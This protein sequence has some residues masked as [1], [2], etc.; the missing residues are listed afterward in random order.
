MREEAIMAVCNFPNLTLHQAL[1][2]NLKRLS[3][4]SDIFHKKPNE[5]TLLRL[6]TSLQHRLANSIIKVDST[7]AVYAN[8]KEMEIQKTLE[9]LK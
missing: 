1:Y 7:I 8:G 6:R 9:Q 5:P 4:L 2:H 3:H